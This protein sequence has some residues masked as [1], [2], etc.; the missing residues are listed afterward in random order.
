MILTNNE[1]LFE[2][3]TNGITIITPN[4]RLSNQLLHDFFKRTAGSKIACDKVS[5]VPYSSYLGT[6]FHKARHLYP[7]IKHPILLSSEQQRYL[8]KQILSQHHDHGH[9]GLLAEIQEAWIRCQHWEI[10]STDPAFAQTPQT[11][12]FQLFWHQFQEELDV[13]QALTQEQLSTYLLQIPD[14]FDNTT[15][16]ACFDDYTPQQRSLQQAMVSA[17][18][19]PIFYDLSSENA[20]TQLYPAKDRQD[21]YEQM[22][23]WLKD[24]LAEGK[25]RIGVVIPE[26]QKEFRLMERLLERHIPVDKYN[27]SLGQ[28]LLNTPLVAHAMHFL[29]LDQTLDNHQARLFLQSPYLEGSRSEF[30]AR[31]QLMQEDNL[32]QGHTFPLSSFIKTVKNNA[33]N[34]GSLF[35]NLS[36]Y[37]KE[38]SPSDWVTLFKHRLTELGF[39]GD[40]ALDS[41][42]YQYLQRFLSLLDSFMA[43]SFINPM[44]TKTEA[45]NALM[46]LAKSTIFQIQTSTTPIQILGLLE[47]SGCTFDSVW[48]CGISDQCLPHKTNFSAFIPI[49]TQRENQMPHAVA[50]RELQFAKQLIRRLQQGCQESVFSYPRLM[51]DVPNLPS[52]LIADLPIYTTRQLTEPFTETYLTEQEENYDFPLRVNE[53]VK[54]GTA[55]LANQAKCPFRAFAK[56]R[57]HA[58]AAPKLSDGL[59]P[60]ERGKLIHDI[61]DMLWQGLGTQQQ[62]KLLTADALEQHI[63][64]AIS[65]ALTQSMTEREAPYPA[66]LQSIETER[67]QRLVHASLEWEK[68]RESFVIEAVEQEFTPNLAGIDF[69]VRVDRL[70]KLESGNKWVIDYK[71]KLPIN[72]PWNED[73]PE[74][75]Q[76][77]L[78]ALLDAEINA[79]LFVQLN[80]GRVTCS[81]LSEESHAIRGMSTL[82]K[83]DSWRERQQQWH[84][85]LTDLAQEFQDGHCPPSPFRTSTC[86]RCDFTN[87]C[88]IESM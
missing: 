25:N 59:S 68:Q 47:A 42:N 50:A 13:R 22:I 73:R 2:A 5:C 44:M 58:H 4:N 20:V 30:Q 23:H 40:Y 53:P 14:I 52:P 51:G 61:M 37:P 79:L 28:P 15:L 49:E 8:W 56:H 80:A 32:L 76:L 46:D 39:P 71:T 21:E 81:G 82:K 74:E 69:R 65:Q 62:L 43:L 84:Q 72:K 10:D 55:L 31:S 83:D 67:L 78:Y 60:I 24:Q 36:N 6:L 88:R 35:N 17:G 27:I 1:N 45:I 19:P 26:L 33:P 63:N 57:L 86:Q 29:S 54:G 64:D 41:A 7:N 87:L 9:E 85:Q 66:L 12:L 75:P 11:D 70:D 16:W 48:V 38:A 3:M 34:L 77:L 18:Y